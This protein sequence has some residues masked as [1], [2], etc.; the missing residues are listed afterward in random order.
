MASEPEQPREEQASTQPDGASEG[1]TSTRDAAKQS[2]PTVEIRAPVFE[3]QDTIPEMRALD[4]PDDIQTK[5]GVSRP[6]IVAHDTQMEVRPP[7]VFAGEPAPTALPA[8]A[9]PAPAPVAAAAAAPSAT[10]SAT[11]GT[12]GEAD[13]EPVDPLVAK[14]QDIVTKRTVEKESEVSVAR[15]SDLIRIIRDLLGDV[16]TQLSPEDLQEQVKERLALQNLRERHAALLEQ[17]R[18]AQ[19]A[20]ANLETAKANLEAENASLSQDY[21]SQIEQLKEQIANM[22]AEIARLREQLTEAEQIKEDAVRDV[23]KE[24][25]RLHVELAATNRSAEEV[26]TECELERDGIAARAQ[27]L[28]DLHGAGKLSTTEIESRMAELATLMA[29]VEARIRALKRENQYAALVEEH[30]FSDIETAAKG[31]VPAA[32]SALGRVRDQA[33]DAAYGVQESVLIDSV[34]FKAALEAVWDRR[35]TVRNVVRLET[36]SRLYYEHRKSLARWYKAVQ[37][38][39]EPSEPVESPLAS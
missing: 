12:E 17:L 36:I 32:E 28:V 37:R 22:Q 15:L 35:G 10:A 29:N 13:G 20:C 9:P 5:D 25:E 18:L 14:I 2:A 34:L 23:W 26:R 6:E 31:L 30:P 16:G 19:E 11:D 4:D 38:E 21:E 39:V 7:S 8:A 1:T 3:L 27:E 33:V 24:V